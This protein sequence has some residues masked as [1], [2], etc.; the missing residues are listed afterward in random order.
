MIEGY[1]IFD[2]IPDFANDPVSDSDS[3]VAKKSTG[4]RDYIRWDGRPLIKLSQNHTFDS[5]EPVDE[6]LQQFVTNMGASG[7]FWVPTWHPDFDMVTGLVNGGN[8]LVI[9]PV[10]Y[11]ASYLTDTTVFEPGHYLA[12]Y[13]ETTGTLW[14]PKVLSVAVDGVSGYETLTLSENSPEDFFTSSTIV[15]LLILSRYLDDTLDIDWSS[16]YIADAN[17]EMIQ[18]RTFT[19]AD[20]KPAFNDPTVLTL[21]RQL[22]TNNDIEAIESEGSRA[23]IVGEFTSADVIEYDGN[24][25]NTTETNA[26]NKCA[27]FDMDTGVW[28]SWNPSLHPGNAKS[29]IVDDK[30]YI[31]TNADPYLKAYDKNTGA[32]DSGFNP[33][34]RDV[35]V[36]KLYKTGGKVI[37]SGAR[38]PF[39]FETS[40][41]NT[42]ATVYNTTAEVDRSFHILD[43]SGDPLIEV[44]ND[45][46]ADAEVWVLGVNDGYI[47][48]ASFRDYSYTNRDYILVESG[49]GA[50]ELTGTLSLDS[51]NNKIYFSDLSDILQFE[52]SKFI[53]IFNSSDILNNV[54]IQ[55]SFVNTSVGYIQ[56]KANSLSSDDST[57]YSPGLSLN[58]LEL[59]DGTGGTEGVSLRIFPELIIDIRGNGIY[60]MSVD[61]KFDSFFKS[62]ITKSDY[63]WN[64][65]TPIASFPDAENNRL[66]VYG[67]LNSDT[68][69]TWVLDLETGDVPGNFSNTFGPVGSPG[70]ALPQVRKIEAAGPY[71]IAS[72]TFGSYKGAIKCERSTGSITTSYGI[73]FPERAISAYALVSLDGNAIWIAESTSS[74][75][76]TNLYK[77]LTTDARYLDVPD[78]S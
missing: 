13:N 30:A 38:A 9:H 18:S 73:D 44:E 72:G 4:L 66:V 37:L 16:P 8:Q 45:L 43:S 77:T 25:W 10:G 51:V 74:G 52:N 59:Q 11:E 17:L 67:L 49:T 68:L 69:G 75:S 35:D 46:P 56:V 63:N 15:S 28:D 22:K 61:G 48:F 29:L 41:N 34:V 36:P 23:F 47:Y 21:N 20:I 71:L 26:R 6:V 62:D 57:F 39:P 27:S 42:K 7:S 5:V 33:D 65:Y 55:V 12:I 70:F 54:P 58:S 50:V 60:R 3:I 1:P 78:L 32:L 14:T 64:T 19:A 2:R 53:K 31:L 40:W 24:N 76:D